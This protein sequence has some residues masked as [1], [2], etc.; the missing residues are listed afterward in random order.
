MTF[1]RVSPS[2]TVLVSVC[3]LKNEKKFTPLLKN[4]PD[5]EGRGFMMSCGMHNG[6]QFAVFVIGSNIR[7]KST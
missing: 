6:S 7:G 1:L 3:V 5:V 4:T 2:D